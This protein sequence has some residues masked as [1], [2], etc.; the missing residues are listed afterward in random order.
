MVE[1]DHQMMMMRVK[2]FEMESPIFT[3]IDYEWLSGCNALIRWSGSVQ[4]IVAY[5]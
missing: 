1:F 5:M 4:N 3:C 2:M